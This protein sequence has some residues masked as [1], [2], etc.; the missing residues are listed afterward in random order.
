[1]RNCKD[2]RNC[3]EPGLTDVSRTTNEAVGADRSHMVKTFL[4]TVKKIVF[5][6]I[7]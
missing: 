1:M 7:A 3:R 2:P 4:T 6:L 5:V